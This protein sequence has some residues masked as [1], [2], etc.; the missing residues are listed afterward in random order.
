M[1]TVPADVTIGDFQACDAFD[2][3]ARLG[4]IRIPALVIGGSADQMAPPKYADYLAAHLPRAR[5]V[6]IEGAG[7]MVHAER[8]REVNAAIRGFLTELTIRA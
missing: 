6:A 5:R 4:E 2:V 3:M 1:R 8:P 7:H